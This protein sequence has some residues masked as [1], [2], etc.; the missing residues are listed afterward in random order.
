MLDN[1]FSVIS[2]IHLKGTFFFFFFLMDR[3]GRVTLN[4]YFI[5]ITNYLIKM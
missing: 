4:M 2:F 5:T 3:V 1:I